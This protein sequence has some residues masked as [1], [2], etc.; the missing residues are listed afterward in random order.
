M[1]FGRTCSHFFRTLWILT[2]VALNYVHAVVQAFPLTINRSAW[3][4]HI[5]LFAIASVL[6]IAVYSFHSTLAGRLRSSSVR[7]NVMLLTA[8]SAPI[9]SSPVLPSG[10]TDVLDVIDKAD[11]FV[12]EGKWYSR[13][14]FEALMDQL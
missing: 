10:E 12:F 13:N 1:G 7:G 8:A 6:M 4:A 9:S 5:T 11:R 14:E 2:A 3:Y